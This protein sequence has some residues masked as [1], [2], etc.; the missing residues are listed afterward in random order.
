MSQLRETVPSE[1][2]QNPPLLEIK[3]LQTQF[4]TANGVIRAV[5][6]VS[7][8]LSRGE[9]LGLIGESGCGKSI[10]ALSILRLIRPPGKITAGQIWLG[11]AGGIEKPI[12]LLKLPEREM[13]SVRGSRIAM[14]FQEPMTALNPVLTIGDQIIEAIRAHE[15]IN[16]RSAREKAIAMLQAVAFPLPHVRMKDYPHQLSGGLRQRAMIAMALAPQPELL[17]ADEPTTALDVTIQSQILDL[18]AD[19]RERFHLSLLL[20]S[21]DLG[22][23]AQVADS[24][25]IMYAGKI[26]EQAPALQLF[27]EP[28]HPYTQAL[29]SAV[30]RLDSSRARLETIP[31]GVPELTALPSGC[32]FQ[33]RC[34]F[35]MGAICSSSPIPMIETGTDHSVRCVKYG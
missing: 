33:P 25:A 12:D 19:L 3:N 5:D 20:I 6:D 29:L 28:L 4:A 27:E 2:A 31:G 34:K 9:T 22:V 21:H 1:T 32:A 35:E 13:R 8:S 7:F 18:L 30:P 26:V 10:T 16:L 23:I 15:E 14:I 11:G 24:V 17:I